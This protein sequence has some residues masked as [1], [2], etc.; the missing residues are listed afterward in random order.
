MNNDIIWYPI[1]NKQDIYR[2]IPNI[3]DKM[4]VWWDFGCNDCHIKSVKFEEKEGHVI[5]QVEH[6]CVGKFGS[7]QIATKVV[8][9]SYRKIEYNGYLPNCNGM[10]CNG[11]CIY[12]NAIGINPKSTKKIKGEVNTWKMWWD[13]FAGWYG[14][15]YPDKTKRDFKYVE[16][17]D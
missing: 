5:G 10:S 9:Q 13:N 15:L 11:R 7:D 1:H 8:Y 12:V 3:P 2:L 16:L 4:C 14:V 17:N 6:D